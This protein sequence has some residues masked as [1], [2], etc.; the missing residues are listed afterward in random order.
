MGELTVN[1]RK[2]HYTKIYRLKQENNIENISHT[3]ST[4]SMSWY[5]R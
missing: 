5:R 1:L 4:A 2:Q 3:M